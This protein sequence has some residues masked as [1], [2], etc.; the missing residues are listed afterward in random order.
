VEML[1]SRLPKVTPRCRPTVQPTSRFMPSGLSVAV[2]P[3]PAGRV[4][5]T[6]RRLH[7][8]SPAVQ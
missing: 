8:S 2:V 7:N 1:R 5:P 3:G 6:S 4:C